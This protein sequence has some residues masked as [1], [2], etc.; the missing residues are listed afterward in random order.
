MT[1]RV[2]V[3]SS[4]IRTARGALRWQEITDRTPAVHA[5]GR[6]VLTYPNAAIAGHVSALLTHYRI[7]H[8]METT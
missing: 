4:A 2:A 7:P 1:A 5:G 3:D 6:D 8:Q